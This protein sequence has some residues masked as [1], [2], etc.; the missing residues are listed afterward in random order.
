[1]IFPPRLGD[2]CEG[3]LCDCSRA[4]TGYGATSVYGAMLPSHHPGHQRK[5]DPKQHHGFQER[6]SARYELHR[7]HRERGISSWG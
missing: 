2:A 5:P 6:A 3:A 1:M 4:G 7:A